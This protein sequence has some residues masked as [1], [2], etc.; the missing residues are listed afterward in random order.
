MFQIDSVLTVFP[1]NFLASAED[2]SA[3]PKGFA[4]ICRVQCDT[5]LFDQDHTTKPN[6][7][8]LNTLKMNKEM[9]LNLPSPGAKYILTTSLKH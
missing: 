6:H 8:S 3:S 4:A 5:P 1:V 7:G 2:R 9:H